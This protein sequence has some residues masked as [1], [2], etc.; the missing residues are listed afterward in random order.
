MKTSTNKEYGNGENGFII[1]NVGLANTH[2]KENKMIGGE[3]KINISEDT[4]DD[5]VSIDDDID[6]DDN[7]SDCDDSEDS[8]DN[9]GDG[10]D[11]N[12]SEVD[13]VDDYETDNDDNKNIQKVGK[14]VSITPSELIQKFMEQDENIVEDDDEEEEYYS[15]EDYVKFDKEINE[16]Q[17]LNYHNDLLQSNFDEISALTKIARN[18]EGII[19][20]PLHKTIPILTKFERARIL[21]LRAKQLANGAEPFIKIEPNI[22]Q[23]H[24]ISEMELEQNVL[25]FIVCRP[26]PNGRKEYWRL[27]DLEQIDY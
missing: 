17:V 22:I 5:N 9:I 3:E 20:D 15:D 23:N 2:N 10:D 24:I 27:Q 26:L 7:T 11:D 6:S 1:D 13:H 4:I 18:K 21:G 12:I 14:N 25:P 8:D 16:D 19:V